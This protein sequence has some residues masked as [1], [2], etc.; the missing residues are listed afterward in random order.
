M[1]TAEPAPTRRQ[2]TRHRRHR[3]HRRPDSR[4]AP[5]PDPSADPPPTARLFLKYDTPPPLGPGQVNEVIDGWRANG[6]ADTRER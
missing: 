6:W 2:P 5:V 4:P 1:T 3:R